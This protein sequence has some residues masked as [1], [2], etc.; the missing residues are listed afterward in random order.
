LKDVSIPLDMTKDDIARSRKI[1]AIISD[2][3]CWT[4]IHRTLRGFYFFWRFGLLEKMNS[5]FVAVVSY[6]V[7]RFFEANTAQSAACVY[8]PRSGHV[9]RLFAQFVC[10]DLNKRRLN[11]IGFNSL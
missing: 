11:V 10:H 3:E 4:H 8:I 9:L 1:S 2:R 7:C 5:R 6:E